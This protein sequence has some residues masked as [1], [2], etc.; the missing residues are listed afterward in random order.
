M[1][2]NV[3]SQIRALLCE[4]TSLRRAIENYDLGPK[5]DFMIPPEWRGFSKQSLIDRHQTLFP[6]HRAL[7]RQMK[8]EQDYLDCKRYAEAHDDRISGQVPFS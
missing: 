3:K 2:D 7:I 6:E 1:E 4:M 5:Y 8:C